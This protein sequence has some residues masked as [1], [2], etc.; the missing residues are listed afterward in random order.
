MRNSKVWTDKDE[1]DSKHKEQI[2]ECFKG[3]LIDD[4]VKI[5]AKPNL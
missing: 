3:A 1:F 5:Y 4:Q 2:R